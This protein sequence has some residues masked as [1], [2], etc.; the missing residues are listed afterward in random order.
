MLYLFNDI[1]NLNDDFPERE[2]SLLSLERQEKVQRIR[3]Q[4]GKKE[5]AAAYLLLR[6]ALL[7]G[8]G[9]TEIVEFDYLDKGKPLLREYPYIHFSLSHTNNV[10]ACVVSNSA[11]GVDVQNIRVV[12]DKAAKRV[13]T[14]EE[15][16]GFRKAY[17]PDEYFCEIWAIKES[18]MK[19]TGLGMAA[20]FKKMPV[21]DIT[22]IKL[23]R[24][25][26]YYCCVS[27]IH[28]FD[29]QVNY[30]RREDFEKLYN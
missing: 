8:Y 26:N 19:K 20:A 22:E 13:L 21:K 27:G 11:V 24:E 2:M 7:E 5:S 23:F 9:I 18:Y 3:S 17:N 10:A 25:K 4:S 14:E 6:L 1:E 29:M 28:S 16:E 15:Y 12:T 30:I